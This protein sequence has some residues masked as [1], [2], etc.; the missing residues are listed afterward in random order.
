MVLSGSTVY[1]GCATPITVSFV[2][3][4][5]AVQPMAPAL[6]FLQSAALSNEE[7]Y[8]IFHLNAADV[9]RLAA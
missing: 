5:T 7:R 4:R 6:A 2:L 3:V 1:K 8:S 9:F